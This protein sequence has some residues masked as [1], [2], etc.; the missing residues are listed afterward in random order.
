MSTTQ[1]AAGSRRA[2]D[3]TWRVFRFLAR[4]WVS[5]QAWRKRER[6]LDELSSLSNRGLLLD[7]GFT[8]G[9]IDR[10]RGLQ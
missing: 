4:C 8:R 3:P 9:E 5:F 7:I 1:I 2:S 6:P 10:I